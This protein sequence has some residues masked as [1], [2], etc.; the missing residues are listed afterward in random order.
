MKNQIYRIALL[1]QVIVFGLF[2]FTPVYASDSDT[3]TVA[4]NIEPTTLNVL[5]LKTETDII[6]GANLFQSLIIW[7][8][9]TGDEVTGVAESIDIMPNGKNLKVK[10]RNDV[11]FH[12]GALLTSQDVKFSYKEAANPR[13]SNILAGPL[14]EVEE[15]EIIDNQNLIIRF[16]EPYA[17]CWKREKLILLM[18]F[19]LIR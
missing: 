3:V 15:I 17:P 1:I 18:R 8:Y 4:L 10:L 11:R 9:K 12:N 19:P 14:D 13:N 7:D 5:E 2:V 6:I 16:Y